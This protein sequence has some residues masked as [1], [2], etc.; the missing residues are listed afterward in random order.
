M[1]HAGSGK[2]GIRRAGDEGSLAII[3]PFRERLS[4]VSRQMS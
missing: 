2:P 1:G 4:K 3:A